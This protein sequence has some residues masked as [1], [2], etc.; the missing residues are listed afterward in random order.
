MIP[1]NAHIR[2][3]S[4]DSNGGIHIRRRGYSFTDGIDP[5][6][7]TLLGGLFFIAY[8]QSPT[9]SSRC[10]A[11]SA[12]PTRST[13]TSGTPGAASSSA[14]PGLPEGSDWSAQLLG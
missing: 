5:E 2:L 10:S 7:G 6:L 1:D 9:S 8:M 14:R 3:A 4:P 11:G 13:S 12:T